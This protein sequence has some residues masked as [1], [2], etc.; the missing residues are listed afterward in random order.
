M[1]TLC[2]LQII[3]N[4]LRKMVAFLAFQ[5]SGIFS[6]KIVSFHLNLFHL[7]IY[8]FVFFFSFI[9]KSIFI[10]FSAF[11]NSTKFNSFNQK[12]K[13]KPKE[14]TISKFGISHFS[15]MFWN[16]NLANSSLD[17]MIFILIHFSHTHSQFTF[18]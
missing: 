9:N 14:K 1:E 7:F 12:T 6:L 4:V 15:N 11:G 17:G 5:R 13:K 18:I 3:K 8:S 2:R 10:L 16:N